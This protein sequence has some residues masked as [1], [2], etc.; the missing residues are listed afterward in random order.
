MGKVIY[1]EYLESD[2]KSLLEK[3]FCISIWY[4]RLPQVFKGN[5]YNLNMSLL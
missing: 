4:E 1:F 3:T 2:Q 5:V